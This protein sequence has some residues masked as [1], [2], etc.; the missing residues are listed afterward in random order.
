MASSLRSGRGALGS[1]CRRSAASSEIS[2]TF[3]QRSEDRA[4]RDRSSRSRRMP[5]D[6]VVSP[7]RSPGTR[8]MTSSTPRVTAK[9]ASAGW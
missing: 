5:V 9:R 1:S 3:T 4:M 2:E 8:A 7:M 6:L